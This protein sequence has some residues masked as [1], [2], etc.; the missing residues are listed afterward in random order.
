M[1]ILHAPTAVG[2]CGWYLAKNER[3]LGLDSTCVVYY[4]TIFKP[5][6]DVNLHLEKYTGI[7]RKAKETSFFVKAIGKYDVFHFNFGRS[8]LSYPKLDLLSID[9][10]ML[11]HLRKKI[12]VTFQGC[13]ARQRSFCIKKF[14]IS[15]CADCVECSKEMDAAKQ[16]NIKWFGFYAHKAFF[17]NPDHG[18]VIPNAEFRPYC[19]VD[20]DEW[21]P[22]RTSE[23]S[24]KTLR[25]LHAPTGRSIKGT[26]YICDAIDK[27]KKE[28]DFIDF[29]L[30]ENIPYSQVKRFYESM[31]ILIDQLLIGWYGG[32]AVEAMA[33]GKPVVSYIRKED[34][35][36][37]PSGMKEDLPIINANPDNIY[38]VL[39]EFI[40]RREVL[41]SIGEE[42]RAYVE[43]W[44]NPIRIAE[45]MRDYYES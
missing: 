13:D 3:K 11:R 43:R 20:L 32:V 19:K 44:H 23:E 17:H 26:R 1:K 5:L 10:P 40:E 31:D 24:S 6:C 30:V 7:L 35:R 27:L 33:L 8:L 14:D 41:Q 42:S 45:K 2:E 4:D 21:A 28:Y 38:D 16:K 37:I 34:L 12:F 36:F 15:A 22:I 25:I 18:Y 39:K 9:L 29:A